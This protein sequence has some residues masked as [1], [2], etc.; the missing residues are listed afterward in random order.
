MLP[1]WPF[2]V[3]CNATVLM[4]VRFVL[5]H[6]TT[7]DVTPSPTCQSVFLACLCPSVIVVEDVA[8]VWP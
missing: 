2:F 5:S 4:L 8:V 7:I 1:G 3:D 6:F